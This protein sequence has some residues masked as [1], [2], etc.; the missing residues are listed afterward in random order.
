MFAERFDIE[1]DGEF[2]AACNYLPFQINLDRRTRVL[3]GFLHQQFNLLLGEADRKDSVFERIVEKDVCKAFR[4]N[5]AYAHV[6]DRPRR[7]FAG[8]A[9]AE[10]FAG[11][12]NAGAA[13]GSLVQNEVGFFRPV[14]VIT[15][16][17]EGM[18]PQSGAL[19]GFQELLGNDDVGVD[20][21]HAEGRGNAAELYKLFHALK[22]SR[23][24]LDLQAF[25]SG[26]LGRNNAASG[27]GFMVFSN[28]DLVEFGFMLAVHVLETGAEGLVFALSIN[29]VDNP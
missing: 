27:G 9:T 6:E 23:K 25:Q 12:Q 28:H 17:V 22:I 4:D 14:L 11:D 19:Y 20:I 1:R 7:M 18:Y 29:L 21:D 10:I 15:D 3:F 5:A 8:G 24:S 2:V 16:I 26:H 13:I